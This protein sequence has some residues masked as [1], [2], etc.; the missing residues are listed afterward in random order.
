MLHDSSECTTYANLGPRIY[1]PLVVSWDRLKQ[2]QLHAVESDKTISDPD[3]ISN[4]TISYSFSMVKEELGMYPSGATGR[5]IAIYKGDCEWSVC[6]DY[7]YVGMHCCCALDIYVGMMMVGMM[8]VLAIVVRFKSWKK[9]Q[10]LCSAA[11]LHFARLP[12]IR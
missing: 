11:N 7:E 10:V 8:T 4:Q 1:D 2:R 5:V 12:T 3:L 9:S 6:G